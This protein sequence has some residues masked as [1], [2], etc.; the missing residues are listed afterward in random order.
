MTK[1][2]FGVS[3]VIPNFNGEKL[4]EKNLL[5]LLN[6]KQNSRNNILEIIIVDDGSTDESV[7]LVNSK[8]PEIKIIKHKRNRGIASAI[9]TG[10]RASK[11]Q[12]ILILDT[13]VLPEED[14]L[15]PVLPHFKE[16]RVFAVSLHEKGY[17]WEKVFWKDGYLEIVDGK[18]ENESHNTFYVKRGSGVFRRSVWIELGGSDEKL[19]SPFYWEDLDI[20]YRAAKRGYQNTWEPEAHVV[21]DHWSTS[22]KLPKKFIE[23]IRKRNELLFIW[24]NIHSAVLI[25]KHLAGMF[26]RILISPGYIKIVFMAA[27]KLSLVIS[28]RKREIKESKVSDEAIFA[29]SN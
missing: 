19:F 27:G 21:H 6:A 5:S 4:L 12:L 29:R 3:V 22:G 28:K 18:E 15:V 8:F 16:R 2:N 14:F 7:K 23:N 20:C 11:G 24:K 13:D 25:K 17:G 10:V 9:N 1:N 26:K